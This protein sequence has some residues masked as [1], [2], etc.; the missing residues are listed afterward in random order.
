MNLRVLESTRPYGWSMV[1]C[2]KGNWRHF[3]FYEVEQKT[4]K[5]DSPRKAGQ[6]HAPVSWEKLPVGI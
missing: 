2:G 3:L 6:T 5:P 1:C 4:S